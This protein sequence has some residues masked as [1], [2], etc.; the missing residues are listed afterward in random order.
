MGD[1]PDTNPKSRFG[2]AK[3]GISAIPPVALLHCGEA[4]RDGEAKYGLF[5]WRE[6]EVSASVYYN[7]AFRH[8]AAWWEGEKC[9]QD[10]G[11][12]HLGHV[13]ACCA[14]LIDAETQGQLND[15]R[16]PHGADFQ[17]LV[18]AMTKPMEDPDAGARSDAFDRLMSAARQ[19][20][21]PQ[22]EV[23]WAVFDREDDED[24]NP[25]DHEPLDWDE[26]IEAQSPSLEATKTAVLNYIRGGDRRTRLQEAKDALESVDSTA[27]TVSALECPNDRRRFLERLGLWP[28]G[29][30][31]G[32]HDGRA[33][34]ML[35]LPQ[36]DPEITYDELIDKAACYVTTNRASLPHYRAFL[37]HLG[38][39]YVEG[40]DQMQRTRLAFFIDCAVQE[41]E[42]P[43]EKV[44]YLFDLA[45]ERR[46]HRDTGLG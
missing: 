18:D 7:A 35:D 23:E 11:V 44:D 13:M 30:G 34:F 9:A 29:A 8:L 25:A 16:T 10:S 1:L 31:E 39:R 37:D 22:P 12:H 28:L 4:M 40:Y 36:P 43:A 41:P 32:G 26:P 27:A 42:I 20:F 38:N 6:H 2:V 19:V 45:C 5:N 24:Y 33:S 17:A 15:D 14:I 46:A 3:P 21:H